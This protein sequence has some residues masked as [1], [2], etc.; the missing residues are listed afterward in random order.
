M[1]TTGDPTNSTLHPGAAGAGGAD[2]A[3]GSGAA[4]TTTTNAADAAG[5]GAAR[6]TTSD[7]SP[8]VLKVRLDQERERGA[9]KAQDSLFEQYGV[10]SK[11]E[12]DAK[13]ARLAQLDESDK[14]RAAEEDEKKRAS[15]TSEEKLRAENV[16]LRDRIKEL[17]AQLSQAQGKVA[18]M[19]QGQTVRQQAA[20]LIDPDML[21]AAELKF[22]A[23][24]RELRERG[25]T[26]RVS[27]Y[28]KPGEIREYFRDLAAR[29]PKFARGALP[30]APAAGTKAPLRRPITT[31]APPRAAAGASPAKI[32]A[33]PGGKTLRP[34]SKDTMSDEEAAKHIANKFPGVRVPG[35]TSNTNGRSH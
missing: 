21:D 23:H 29:V 7:L 18:S 25:E 8:E 9:R 35:L 28:E 34:G 4:G 17:E 12:L 22:A 2:G 13:L 32:T 15:M 31:G 30:P 1:T 11:E 16:A 27:K 6:P 33:T 3:A 5:A 24:I 10:R 19:R 26:A 14:K 20:D